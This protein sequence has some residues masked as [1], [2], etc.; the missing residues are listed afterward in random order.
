MEIKLPKRT[1][2]LRIKH[3]NVLTN[4]IYQQSMDLQ[5]VVDFMHDF[6]G[7]EK[8][9]LKEIDI[10]ELMQMYQ[11]AVKLYAGYKP[12]E[13][14]KEIT[15]NGIEYQMIDPEKV[16]TGWHIDFNNTD[17]T[18]EFVRLA[19]LFYYPKGSRYG[20]VD[21]N[22][23]LK[24]PI[25]ERYNDFKEHFPLATFL[26]ASAFFFAKIKE[27]NRRIHGEPKDEGGN[28]QA[29]QKR[30]EWEEVIHAISQEFG[31]DW[32]EITDMNYYTF[33]HRVNFLTHIIKKRSQEIQNVR[34]K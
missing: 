6:T 33:M 16:S 32:Y 26:D 31:L 30:Y 12:Q 5:L 29:T 10:K 24:H 3:Y 7:V 25:H 11:H 23:N 20:E 15:V 17:V 4:P 13:P 8:H 34:R 19:C 22:K 14:P 9:V 28:E 2:D 1:E 27:I 21:E 18:R